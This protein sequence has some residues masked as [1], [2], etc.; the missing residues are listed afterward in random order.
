MAVTG[1]APLLRLAA[2]DKP[3]LTHFAGVSWVG[4]QQDNPASEYGI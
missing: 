2:L 3:S 4:K 1:R